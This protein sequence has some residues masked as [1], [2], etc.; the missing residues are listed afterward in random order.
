MEAARRRSYLFEAALTLTTA[1]LAVRFLSSKQVFRWASRPPRHVCRFAI[2][3][4]PWISW[5][6]QTAGERTWIRARCLPRALAAQAMLRRRG[7]ASRVC[8]AGDYQDEVVVATAW[9]EIDGTIVVGDADAG[10]LSRIAE[11]G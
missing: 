8:I 7:I 11:F 2:Q 6:I 4:V 3:E 5:A 10:S 1:G 9:L